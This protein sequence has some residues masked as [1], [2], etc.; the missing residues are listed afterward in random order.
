MTDDKF[1]LMGLD[2]ERAGNIAEALK[3]PTC[4]KILNFLGD[5]KEASEKDISD[6]LK[7]PINTIEYNLNKLIKSGL[8]EKTKK[9]FWSV[10]GKKI[11]MYKLARKHIIISPNKN[12]SMNYLKTILPVILIAVLVIVL[13]GIILFPKQNII[14]EQDK[15]KQFASQE[16][17]TNFIKEN[18][19]STG[20]SNM[21]R[22]FGGVEMAI[23]EAMA[24]NTAPTAVTGA[25]EKSSVSAS[26]YS[27]TNIQVQGVDEADIVKNDDKYIYVVNGNK[28][29]IINAYPAEDMDI[30]SEINFNESNANIGN[31]FVNKD[32]LIV[33]ASGYGPILYAK[34]AASS[35]IRC[36]G[37][38]GYEQ[39]SLV[40]IYDISDKENPELENEISIE[41]NYIDSRM[42]NNYIY[43]VSTKYVNTDNPEPP[44]YYANGVEN[45]VSA[46]DVYYWPYSDTSYVFTSIMAVDIENKDFNNKVYLTGSTNTIFVSQDN[47]YLTYQKTADYKEYAEQIAEEVYYPLLPNEYDNKIKKVLDSDKNNWEKLSEMKEIVN[48]YGNSLENSKDMSDFSAELMKN[49]EEFNV[50]IQKQT[51][52]TIVHKIN[53]NK[54]NIEYKGVGEVPGRILNQFS[55]DEYK[56]NFRIATTTGNWRETSL[57]HLYVLDKDLKI[58]GSVED[59]AKGERIYST[60]FIGKR[61]YM[62]TFKQ[63][64]PL[65]VI[66]LS[67]PEKPEVLGYLKITGFSDYLHPYD[68]DHIIGIGKEATEQGRF[69]GLKISLFDVSDVQNPIEESEIEIGDRGTDSNALYNHRAFLFD[70]E[71]N[72]LVIPISVY[73]SKEMGSGNNVWMG[74]DIVFNGA[75]VFNIDLNEISLRGKITHFD[76]KSKY[77]PAEDETIGATREIYGQTYTKIAE[78][79][80]EINQ[81]YYNQYSRT[82]Y[83]DEYIDQ[84]P[85]GINYNNLYDYNNQIQRSLYMDDVL[86]TISQSKIKAND[87]DSVDEINSLDL[88]YEENYYPYPVYETG[89]A[90]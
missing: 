21:L 66:D 26:D 40:Y 62:V 47:I 36:V 2:D 61:A 12:P 83:T 82:T 7:M 24:E 38:G 65:F 16:D 60:R 37:C 88:G 33:F 41:G 90:I 20:Y 18:S 29:K 22:N 70:K 57:N 32:K 44:I 84:Q 5:I 15:I 10:K 25:S 17:L 74:S 72:L 85:G 11:P 81:T 73:E 80:W 56:N 39:N 53:V 77:G 4:K 19:D 51:E 86:Y 30:L 69:L 89:I 54:D 3:N 67:N 8:V 76:S 43:V 6:S 49:L 63:V 78:N 9:F 48:D 64:D 34:E 14:S 1:I 58:I 68:E 79:S 50:K 28:V 42:I 52:K 35:S 13:A 87:L 23:D 59:L 75:Y 71:K 27:T 45:K 31:I 46:S 55:M